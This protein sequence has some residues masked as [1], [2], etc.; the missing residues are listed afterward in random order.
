MVDL[1]VQCVLVANTL[2]CNAN[3]NY[4]ILLNC[5]NIDDFTLTYKA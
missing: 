5:Y 4:W 3:Y 1:G 2:W